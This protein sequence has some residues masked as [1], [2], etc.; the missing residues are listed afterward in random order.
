M[1]LALDRRQFFEVTGKG[2]LGTALLVATAGSAA[3]MI[4]CNV[5]WITTAINDLPTVVSIATTVASIVATALGGGAVTPAVA[6][7]IA[8]AAQAAQVALAL[9]QQLVK[10]YQANPTASVLD[11]IKITLLDIQGNL[12]QILD[13]AHVANSALR[14][15]IV[16]LIGLGITVITQILSL[17]PVTTVTV[18][19]KNAKVQT[20]MAIKPT[21]S[22]DLKKQVN[23][24]LTA[25]GYGQYAIH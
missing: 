12:G 20:A 4:G 14:T 5:D 13:A 22:P 11:K 21:S 23:A 19:L 2:T 8:T 17:L 7:I 16:G 9:V 10:D 6:A 18:A 1:E 25:Y 15:V 24:F 3:V